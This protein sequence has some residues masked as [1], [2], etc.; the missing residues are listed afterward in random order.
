MKADWR[1]KK[2][3][4][5]KSGASKRIK[6]FLFFSIFTLRLFFV[7]PSY[8]KSELPD[9]Q[10]KKFSNQVGQ[11]ITVS[12]NYF[13]NSL[14]YYSQI[15]ENNKVVLASFVKE[16]SN[17]LNAIA[18][19][20][21]DKNVLLGLAFE[22][23]PSRNFSQE[24]G[25]GVL[26]N[27]Q[28]IFEEGSRLLDSAMPASN[29]IKPK[30]RIPFAP[31]ASPPLITEAQKEFIVKLY[32]KL[33]DV[34]VGSLFSFE[35]KAVEDEET[36]NRLAEIISAKLPQVQQVIKEV[37]TEKEIKIETKE[38]QVILNDQKINEL[39]A[40]LV[41]LQQ[42]QET[43]RQNL[44]NTI[45]LS[46]RIN[47]LKGVTITEP[48]FSSGAITDSDIPDTITVSNYIPL[49]G[50]TFTGST[51]VA[52]NFHVS[53]VLNAS[54]TLLANGLS[55]LTGGFI[56]SASST[57]AGSLQ[58]SGPIQ[59]SSSATIANTLGVSGLSTLA[60]FISTA[61]ST[62]SNS[63]QLAGPLSASSTLQV[64][65]NSVFYGNLGIGTTSPS[66]LFSVQGNAFLS[67]SL[68]NVANITA[69]GTITTVNASTTGML[70]VGNGAIVTG[71]STIAGPLQIS[72]PIQASS[73]ATIASTLGVSGLSTLSGFISTASSTI[74]NS[75]Q[76]SGPLSASSTLTVGG[77]SIF[78]GFISTASST[79]SSN[80]LVS[81]VLNASSTI[82]ASNGLSLISG[83]LGIGT[84]SPS[85]LFS[86][87][88]N[89]FLSG[90]LINVANIT[91]TGTLTVR[92]SATS[93]VNQALGIGPTTTPE[94]MLTVM[95]RGRALLGR[96]FEVAG[97]TTATRHSLFTVYESGRIDVGGLSATSTDYSSLRNRLTIFSGGERKL[98]L[99]NTGS[100][101]VGNTATTG[102]AYAFS[103]AG[104]VNIAGS[105]QFGK[106]NAYLNF[107]SSDGTVKS[108]QKISDTAGSF[109]AT[110][111]IN[112]NFGMSVANIGDLD[113]DGVTDLVAGAHKDDDGFT[114]RGAI[115][116]LFMNP[117]GTVKSFQKTSNSFGGYT[118]ANNDE[119]GVSVA[120]IG[121][122]NGD[123]V[124]DLAVGAHADN[125]GNADGGAVYILFMNPAG[126]VKSAQKIS[127]T[128]GSLGV[129]M[130]TSDNFGQSIANIGDLDGDGVTDI[131]VGAFVDDDGNTDGGAVYILFMN[132]DGTVKSNQKISSTAGGLGVTMDTDDQFGQDIASLGDLDG[133]GVTD[134]VVGAH[135]DDD[136]NTDGGAAYILFM[137]PDGTVKSNQK[138]SS[139]AGNFGTTLVATDSFGYSVA[140]LGDLDGDSVKDIVVGARLDN[141][142]N[143]DGGAVYILFMNPN[144]TVKSKQKISSTAGGL[145]VTM[146]TGDQ[147]GVSIASVGDL[148]GDGITDIAV[149]APEDDDEDAGSGAIYIL[150]MND[151]STFKFSIQNNNATGTLLTLANIGTATNTAARLSFQNNATTTAAL[152][153]ILLQN[154]TNN[155]GTATTSSYGA[156]TFSILQNGLL[157][158][159]SRFNASGTLSLV[160]GLIS[161]AS[162]T[163]AGNLQVA[164]G[165]QASS[166]LTVGSLA[167][168]Y[169]G[170]ISSASSTV[171]SNLHISGVISASSSMAINGALIGATTIGVSASTPEAGAIYVEK[172]G[173][174]PASISLDTSN[175]D[176]AI[177]FDSNNG[178]VN[179]TIGYDLSESGFVL[180][181]GGNPTTG[182]A[183]LFLADGG[184]ITM[185]NNGGS[186]GIGTTTPSAKLAVEQGSVNTIGFYLSGYANATA[187]LFRVST[188][189]AT[190][191]STAFVIDSQG[192]VGIGTSTP[193]AQLSIE[194]TCIDN[195][196][197]CADYA[198][199]Y[200]ASESVEAGE[201]LAL[202]MDNP[203]QVKKAAVG[204]RDL[205]VGAVSSN[206]AIIIEGSSLQLLTGAAY[207]NNP[208]KP[209]VA[210]AGRIPVKVN[211]EGGEIKVGDP[212]TASSE[213]GVG[214]KATESGKIIGYA[215]ENYPNQSN[216][217]KIML[218]VSLGH[219]QAPTE[220]TQLPNYLIA[221]VVDVVKQWLE[222]MQVFIE[223]GLVRLKNLVAEKIT[224]Q[225]L[226]VEDVCVDK[227]GLQALLQNAG[228]NSLFTTSTPAIS[229]TSP[230]LPPSDT[231]PPVIALNGPALIEIEIGTVWV[232]PGATVTDNVNDNLGIYYKVDGMET[233]NG[234][235]DLPQI[236]ITAVGAHTIIYIATDQAGNIGSATRE[237]KVIE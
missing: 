175:A 110:L 116:V 215:L 159:V 226:C 58:I 165:L 135:Q 195:G 43:N 47:T 1:Q 197:G 82:F 146:D 131:A 94:A 179:W 121:D 80:L 178:T 158:E 150:F 52:G 76:L 92:G 74:S 42:T 5:K 142:G 112:D 81:G 162:S 222:S 213:A 38:T 23:A 233:G 141:D 128:A 41:Q 111:D 145:G 118:L 95:A 11:F 180:A 161:S 12:Q 101:L 151:T 27:T 22:T 72:G 167:S 204:S 228:L 163:V 53:G 200:P 147:F 63:L 100:L 149:G 196:G 212:I 90:S 205:I 4:M 69:T 56:S 105:L 83:N 87:Q 208:E 64:S 138:I 104:S 26:K 66:Q 224:V 109:T 193:I 36:I 203:G 113:G 85:Q 68:I 129:T 107:L 50:G 234:G 176:P 93:T 15:H 219:W 172:T 187:D 194:G 17:K 237:V 119:F 34:D 171:A 78:S 218:F 20:N 59:A 170:F 229:T 207:K 88:G 24:I 35:K 166:T 122:L 99:L 19:K 86:V 25:E 60:G 191:T 30:E 51:T 91:A 62:I 139:T 189:T 190:A 108:N 201:L 29:F 117:A 114:D 217:N 185:A 199:L 9:F 188:S 133:D 84:T 79:F 130:D 223:N 3:I 45:A 136:G 89:A 97:N 211:L 154:T 183:R 231:E 103:V 236:D 37:R 186:V 77:N 8:A 174:I 54:S 169:N 126:T 209:A 75:L 184:N 152:T 61:S 156:L 164:G 173:G 73:S 55:T 115:Y 134:L 33:K 123:G 227:T 202:D 143:T 148:D 214:K 137:N 32:E 181:Q 177:D 232:D 98:Q 16:I 125:D 132:P 2:E 14:E 48:I 225:Q 153:S 6:L 102:R 210:L 96:I 10:F 182:N 124:T 127:S 168:L 106:K 160:S 31:Q 49:G 120:A 39:Q 46:N 140:S 192:R 235:R 18:L 65:G 21:K 216:V 28:L 67:G 155:N 157:T 220:I 44:F 13:K 40:S 230:S 198:E 206:P 57:I 7:E 221:Q 144:G 70:T 71:S